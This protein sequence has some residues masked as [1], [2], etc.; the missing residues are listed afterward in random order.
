MIVDQGVE[1]P[2]EEYVGRIECIGRQVGNYRGVVYGRASTKGIVTASGLAGGEVSS[3]KQ[4]R[5]GAI[6]IHRSIYRPYKRDG[7]RDLVDTILFEPE[8]MP[9]LITLP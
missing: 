8:G 2:I 9:F 6:V 5:T 3:M 1:I 7:V 4:K